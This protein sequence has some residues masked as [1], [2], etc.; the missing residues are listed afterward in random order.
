[1]ETTAEG[2]LEVWFVLLGRSRRKALGLIRVEVTMKNMSKRNT[3]SVIEDMLKL[4]LGFRAR[5]IMAGRL[6]L[7]VEVVN[8]FHKV[9]RGTF[10]V[11]DHAVNARGEDVIGEV[12]DNADNQS[13]HRRNHRRVNAS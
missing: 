13:C 11:I 10:H 9:G 4:G 1:M 7:V 5:L 12:G 2:W 6:F 3:M 8:S